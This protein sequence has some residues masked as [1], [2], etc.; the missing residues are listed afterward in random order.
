MSTVRFILLALMSDGK[1]KSSSSRRR[2]YRVVRRTYRT[3]QS[4]RDEA[5]RRNWTL[6]EAI[7]LP[8]WNWPTE[9][10]SDGVRV[11]ISE[12]SNHPAVWIQLGPHRHADG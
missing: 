7:T 4:Q 3:P 8:W 1:V 5:Q 10:G 6:Y 12:I 9:A 2:E 11:N